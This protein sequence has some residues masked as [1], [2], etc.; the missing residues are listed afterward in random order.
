MYDFLNRAASMADFKT[1]MVDL[2]GELPDVVDLHG[3]EREQ[4]ILNIYRRN[5]KA[6]MQSTTRY[7]AR[8]AYVRVLDPTKERT[9]YHLVYLTTHH[10]GITVFME[11]SEKLDAVQKLVRARTRQRTRIEKT[12]QDELFS[13]DETAETA[14]DLVDISL[15]ERDWLARLSTEPRRFGEAEFATLME[16]T[17]WLPGDLQR[18]LGNLIEIGKVRNLDA[19][20]KRRSKFLH[21]KDPG[22]RLQMQSE[23]R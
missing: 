7:P 12:G 5:L 3:W 17:D 8:S 14:G 1:H 2:L 22:E 9:K 11:I 21:Y 4:R 15:V 16:E 10:H 20:T 18:A 23:E 19:T 13:A 6:K